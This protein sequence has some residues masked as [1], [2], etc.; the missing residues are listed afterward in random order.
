MIERSFDELLRDKRPAKFNNENLLIFNLA[1]LNQS[2]ICLLVEVSYF[3]NISI[4]VIPCR[5]TLWSAECWR[6]Q[7]SLLTE[8]SGQS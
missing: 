7:A 2:K 4:Y 8:G 6:S 1:K 3:H 5:V